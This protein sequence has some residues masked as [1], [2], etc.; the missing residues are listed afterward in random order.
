M[1]YWYTRT[2]T[3][4]I[5]LSGTVLIALSVIIGGLTQIANA[6][7]IQKLNKTT[8]HWIRWLWL[9]VLNLPLPWFMLKAM[10]WLE[11]SQNKS[12]WFPSVRQIGPTHKEHNS[13]RL[14][15]CTTWSVKA[16][17]SS[18]TNPKPTGVPDFNGVIGV[19]LANC[20]LLPFSP[21]NYHVI[22]AHL[23]APIPADLHTNSVT[24]VAALVFYPLKFTGQLSQLLLNQRTKK[25]T[26]GY[27]I[28]VVLRSILMVLKMVQ[29]LPSVVG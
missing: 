7:E 5:S 24:R 1:G 27:K 23:L 17:V 4:S 13:Q 28:S 6:V 25:F 29:F 3:L 9:I 8:L 15:S 11:F 20:Y 22:S 12:S 2:S 18:L 14:D 21:N 19:H 26:G 10:A 16:G